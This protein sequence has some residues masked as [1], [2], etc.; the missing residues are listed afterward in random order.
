VKYGHEFSEGP[1]HEAPD[2]PS[3]HRRPLS[4]DVRERYT[5]QR[6]RG[7]NSALNDYTPLRSPPHHHP[8]SGVSKDHKKS[9]SVKDVWPSRILK[10]EFIEPL[11]DGRELAFLQRLK[12]ISAA[13]GQV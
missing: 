9:N 5:N 7:Q 6:K 13:C 1:D 2:L 8:Q 10:I 11:D 3:V 12:S 4:G